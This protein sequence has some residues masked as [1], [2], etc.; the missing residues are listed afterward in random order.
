MISL[1]AYQFDLDSVTQKGMIPV[2][3]IRDIIR[4]HLLSYNE[5]KN[6][7]RGGPDVVAVTPSGQKLRMHRSDIVNKYT[8]LSGKKISMIGWKSS[9][10]YTVMRIDST[11]AFAMMVPSNCTVQINGL[12]ANSSGRKKCDYIV[13]LADSTG[14]IDKSTLGIIPNAVFKKMFYMPP[15]DVISR[16]IGKGHKLFGSGPGGKEERVPVPSSPTQSWGSEQSYEGMDFVGQLGMNTDIMNSSTSIND[17]DSDDDFGINDLYTTPHSK[18]INF[19]KAPQP[20]RT[21][22]QP[23]QQSHVKPQVQ[24]AQQI[25]QPKQPSQPQQ[26]KY[27]AIGR[28]VNSDNVLIGFVIQAKTGE[29]RNITIN[30]MKGICQKKLVSNITLAVNTQTGREYLRGNNIRIES[31]PLYQA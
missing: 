11:N 3:R 2:V 12:N 16:N 10:N 7:Q 15:N 25:Q 9:R 13:A 24:Q 22:A 19:D 6:I 1:D 17:S 20:Q 27:I 31:L 8:Y 26:Y 21:Q 28:L 23:R 5:K 18:K 4:V 29:T 30:Q 14:G